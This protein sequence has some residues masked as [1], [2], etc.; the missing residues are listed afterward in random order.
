VGRSLE[1]VW[2]PRWP[3]TL[4]DR[5]TSCVINR[6]SVVTM[7]SSV[8]GDDVAYVVDDAVFTPAAIAELTD[9]AESRALAHASK[10]RYLGG[11]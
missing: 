2:R 7:R 4:V 5:T 9:N 8:I 1:D 10:D 3:R 6:L 11:W